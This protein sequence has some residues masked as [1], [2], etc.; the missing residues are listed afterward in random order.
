MSDE[1][2]EVLE[3]F[4]GGLNTFAAP[5]RIGQNQLTD[6][7]NVLYR[8]NALISRGGITITTSNTLTVDTQTV[9]ASWYPFDAY[10][11]FFPSTAPVETV[12][13]VGDTSSGTTYMTAKFTNDGVTCSDV[14]HRGGT[15]ATTS[16]S[17]IITGT[18]T[19][20]LNKLAPGDLFQ[21]GT[22]DGVAR[23]RILTVD[24]DTQ[25]TLTSNFT[26]TV[27]GSTYNVL[28]GWP[29][30]AQNNSQRL[31]M[32]NFNGLMHFVPSYA[33]AGSVRTYTGILTTQTL[34]VLASF[35]A[36]KFTTPFKNYVFGGNTSA[37]RYR[38]QW[39]ALKDSTTWPSANFIDV[40]PDD[41][42]EIVG[43]I[44]YN[45]SLIIIKRNGVYRLAGDVF[46]P[47]NPTYTLTALSVPPDFYADSDR[48]A[49]IF[50]GQLIIAGVFGMYAISNDV[51]TE[52]PNSKTITATWNAFTTPMFSQTLAFTETGGTHVNSPFTEKNAIVYKDG[53][54]MTG[55][56]NATVGNSP[57]PIVS[58]MMDT[59]GSFWPNTIT[60]AQAIGN[61]FVYG[62]SAFMSTFFFLNG[63]IYAMRG[64]L[65]PNF[66]RFDTGV[67]DL[68]TQMA[69]SAATKVFEYAKQQRFGVSY[70]YFK[71]QSA[72][73]MSFDYRVD[74]GSY[75]TNTIDMTAGT[76]TRVKSAP[77]IIG[78]VGRSIQFRLTNNVASAGSFEIYAISYAR[79]ELRQ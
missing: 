36:V 3:D 18:G 16:G 12:F 44:P 1:K 42:Q 7:F 19:L 17:P 79:K 21:L 74:E 10:N 77:I 61:N 51:V 15:V 29:W 69:A 52:L 2:L 23:F 67:L 45:S 57:G 73:S 64:G 37:N 33:L 54:Y 11:T 76:G 8:N 41:G 6:A 75:V 30:T 59:K 20:W 72:G 43:M 65:A 55:Q 4:S 53:Y 63:N 28:M 40:N 25:I 5:N 70:L 58:V 22:V 31:R 49:K 50:N 13:L 32:F 66:G 38:V 27:S 34:G 46:D 24:T 35:P 71:K 56:Y 9:A 60:F 14:R 47:T 39:S 48:T 62:E 78:R 68:G 26:S